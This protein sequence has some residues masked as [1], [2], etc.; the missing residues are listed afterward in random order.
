MKYQQKFKSDYRHIICVGFTVFSLLVGILFP[1]SLPRIAETIRDL[2]FSLV[3]YVVEIFTRDEANFIPA[4]VNDLQTWQ[5]CDQ[6][7]API[8][9][10][11]ETWE[12]FTYYWE[13][14]WGLFFSRENFEA[15]LIALGDFF[16]YFSRVMLVVLPLL[17]TVIFGVNS[18]KDKRC[19]VRNLESPQLKKF[20]AFQFK[21]I[22]PIIAWF[23]D[24]G[25]FLEENPEY[26]NIREFD[27]LIFLFEPIIFAS[28]IYLAFLRFCDRS[29]GEVFASL[30]IFNFHNFPS[31]LCQRDPS[32]YRYQSKHL[33][34]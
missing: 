19:N 22:Y 23:K 24:F 17:M 5:F 20:K 6:I 16:F 15:Y 26:K 32:L 29:D 2:L 13:N 31:P 1:N 9:I 18:Y 14:Y 33:L 3:Y 25:V 28:D 27:A 10:L 4:T 30:Q 21:R 7:W 34:F 11:P 8:K 12:E